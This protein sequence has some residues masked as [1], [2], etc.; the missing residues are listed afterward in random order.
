MHVA[1]ELVKQLG[2]LVDAQFALIGSV[3][4]ALMRCQH[5]LLADTRDLTVGVAGEDG[6]RAH[7]SPTRVR[8]DAGKGSRAHR[9]LALQM[10]ESLVRQ[11]VLRHTAHALLPA[12]LSQVKME[13]KSGRCDDDARAQW[14]VL[15]PPASITSLSTVGWRALLVVHDITKHSHLVRNA[16][17]WSVSQRLNVPH[18]RYRCSRYRAR[19]R[20]CARRSACWAQL[21]RRRCSCA[22]CWSWSR[23]CSMR[24]RV[25]T[26]MRYA[27]IL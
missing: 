18:T 8:C 21:V 12:L 15:T 17:V 20:W 24:A 3:L 25:T 27:D 14:F 13:R 11:L 4:L 22:Q 1:Q 10:C 26:S 6:D 16:C 9:R 7:C 19:L 5:A 2:A 23:I